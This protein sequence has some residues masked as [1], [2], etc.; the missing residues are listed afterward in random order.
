MQYNMLKSL[1]IFVIGAL[2][3]GFIEISARGYTHI[4]MGL[5]GGVSM[6]VIHFSNDARREGM[7]YFYQLIII[8][9]FITSIELITGEI[10]NVRLGMR[11]WDYSR[12]PMN[13]DG[14]I[15]LR[16][17]FIWL[18][19]SSAGIIIDDF[20]RWKVFR[21]DKNFIYFKHTRSVKQM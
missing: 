7:N 6:L 16:F 12:V 21:E 5:L 20:I 11:I 13:L 9:V 10:L 2:A 14:Q 3:Y 8:V 19:L 1:I 15:C 17:S 4:S 18:I